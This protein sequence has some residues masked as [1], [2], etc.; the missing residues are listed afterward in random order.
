MRR[1]QGIGANYLRNVRLKSIS[2]SRPSALGQAPGARA[3]V[4]NY[5][6]HVPIH[7]DGPVV[8][9]GTTSASP[10]SPRRLGGGAVA[11][12]GVYQAADAGR[13][14]CSDARPVCAV[15][16]TLAWTLAQS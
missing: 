8:E 9:I 11:H 3:V 6:P 15:A 14:G 16:S 12:A 10:K 5:H 2:H 13:S 4:D 1:Y 7:A